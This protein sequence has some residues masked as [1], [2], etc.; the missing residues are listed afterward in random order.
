MDRL[1]ALGPA[2]HVDVIFDEEWV[3]GTL[4]DCSTSPDR[5]YVTKV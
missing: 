1:S 3:D 2:D 5:P 4:E